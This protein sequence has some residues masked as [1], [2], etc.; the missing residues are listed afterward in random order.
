MF[1]QSADPSWNVVSAEP[2][3]VSRLW[4]GDNPNVD[5]SAPPR[6]SDKKNTKKKAVSKKGGTKTG[7]KKR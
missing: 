6:P 3:I 4:C 5:Q 1:T 7:S 2:A